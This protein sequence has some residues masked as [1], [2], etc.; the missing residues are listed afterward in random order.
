MLRPRGRTTP[1][2]FC[3]S[4]SLFLRSPERHPVKLGASPDIATPAPNACL[5]PDSTARLSLT[6][7]DGL[8]TPR[9]KERL[10]SPEPSDRPFRGF[11]SPIVLFGPSKPKLSPS[12]GD[13][14]ER[15]RERV[16]R[17]ILDEMWSTRISESPP[18]PDLGDSRYPASPY[19]H[20]CH[21]CDFPNDR[22]D[23]DLIPSIPSDLQ[24][25]RQ[26]P[27]PS[28]EGQC[29]RPRL[30]RKLLLRSPRDKASGFRSK[31]I[32]RLSAGESIVILAD[33]SGRR[34]KVEAGEV[35]FSTD[36]GSWNASTGGCLY[37]RRL[38]EAIA[39]NEREA[40]AVLAE[41]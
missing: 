12:P 22:L 17:E 7:K 19:S 1:S 27:L 3:V 21:P 28:P 13:F 2:S 38:E 34:F 8:S 6:A 31:R 24:S 41:C 26:E 14:L 18:A 35:T 16:P 32:F 36:G 4:P 20:R 25:D 40:E 9:S 15:V 33:R 29:K 30:R 10:A 5:S 23:P 37:V 11:T 39:R